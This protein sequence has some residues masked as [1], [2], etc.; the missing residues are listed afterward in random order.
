MTTSYTELIKNLTKQDEAKDR[1]EMSRESQPAPSPSL[2]SGAAAAL[3]ASLGEVEYTL[4]P[5]PAYLND[6]NIEV[7]GGQ[8]V[9]AVNYLMDYLDWKGAKDAEG[10]GVEPRHLSPEVRHLV[11][12]VCGLTGGDYLNWTPITQRQI[13]QRLG[14]KDLKTVRERLHQLYRWEQQTNRACVQ[15]Q[16]EERTPGS[17]KFETTKYRPVIVYAAAE[18]IRRLKAKG[19]RPVNKQ[20]NLNPMAEQLADQVTEDADDEIVRREVVAEVAEDMEQADI[21]RRQPKPQKDQQPR[22][23]FLEEREVRAITAVKAWAEAHIQAGY[24]PLDHAADLFLKLQAAIES[25]ATEK[26]RNW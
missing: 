23:R 15:I 4:T 2:P 11:L 7:Q 22:M 12:A 20:G 21:R 24:K 25:A 9:D 10:R 14:V 18:L 16:E 6:K 3:M 17:V 19:M 8:F 5:T 1:Q 26:R 13:A